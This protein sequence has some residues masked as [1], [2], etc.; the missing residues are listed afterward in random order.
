MSMWETFDIAASGMRAQMVR[1]NTTASNLSNVDSVGTNEENTYRAKEPIFRAIQTQAD[2]AFENSSV[3]VQV[4]GIV[5]SKAP[6]RVEYRPNHP[7]AD[8]NGYVHLPNVNVVEEMANMISASRTYQSN[9]EVMNAS[10]Q[11]MLQTLNIGRG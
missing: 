1:L 4:A 5:E 7:L 10:K 2:A 9:A 6:L 3:G 11:M 8:E